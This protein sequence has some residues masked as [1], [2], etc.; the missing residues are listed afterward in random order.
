MAQSSSVMVSGKVKR[1]I[2]GNADR[3]FCPADDSTC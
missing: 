3:E 2:P 1:K